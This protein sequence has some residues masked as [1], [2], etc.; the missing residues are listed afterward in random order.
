MRWLTTV[1]QVRLACRVVGHPLADRVHAND[2]WVAPSAVHI[3]ASLL[4][5]DNVFH[6]T[7]GLT[8]ISEISQSWSRADRPVSPP[9][10]PVHGNTMQLVT[11]QRS[12]WYPLARHP[13]AEPDRWSRSAAAQAPR[14]GHEV[15]L[16]GR[17]LRGNRCN[18]PTFVDRSQVRARGS[19]GGV[20]AVGWRTREWGS[21]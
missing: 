1:A 2:L 9:G 16:S 7:P 6:Y 8:V 5:A 18:M 20:V 17:A 4:T 14:L 12:A 11:A 3:D 15:C 10:S 19:S 21:R 13:A